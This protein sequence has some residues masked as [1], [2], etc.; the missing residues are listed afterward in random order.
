M[1]RINRLRGNNLA[2][3]SQVKDEF[4]RTPLKKAIV[5]NESD[6]IKNI[7]TKYYKWR[8]LKVQDPDIN[9]FDD[10][11]EYFTDLIYNS[12]IEIFNLFLELG[13]DVDDFYIKNFIRR[14][15]EYCVEKFDALK[16]YLND[17]NRF[18]SKVLEEN[19]RQYGKNEKYERFCLT[20]YKH[21][22]GPIAV[23]SAT[24]NDLLRD[25]KM[26]CSEKLLS[27]KFFDDNFKT[28]YDAVSLNH[29]TC[30]NV[31][32]YL[33]TK[34]EMLKKINDRDYEGQTPLFNA[35]HSEIFY[36]KNKKDF[37][38]GDF[39]KIYEEREL[40][41]LLSAKILESHG[42][43]CPD[44]YKGGRPKDAIVNSGSVMYEFV[45]YPHN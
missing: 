39:G 14:C 17:D 13:P 36:K 44:N 21:K 15:N 35:R 34:P 23:N 16:K 2:N 11:K 31:M 18:T 25:E 33:L 1:R 40:E 26:T 4:N 19:F 9:D 5:K 37:R 32:G 30:S 43:E 8:S 10:P 41:S 29:S 38:Y 6:E 3:E 20:Y 27:L 22:F 42:A 7:L 28:N 12:D 24:I 45:G